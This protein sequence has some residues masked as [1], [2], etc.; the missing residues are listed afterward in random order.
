MLGVRHNVVLLAGAHVP[1][2]DACARYPTAKRE[3][4]ERVGKRTRSDTLV[5][6]AEEQPVSAHEGE[7][8]RVAA[9]H[10]ESAVGAGDCV[11]TRL[12]E[13]M[14]LNVADAARAIGSERTLKR[15]SFR[16]AEYTISA[17]AE[18]HAM[19]PADTR[20]P[21]A[22]M[23]RA[24]VG[25]AGQEDSPS[26]WLS[27]PYVSTQEPLEG[28][29]VYSTVTADVARLTCRPDANERE[30]QIDTQIACSLP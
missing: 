21:S 28:S 7:S 25:L 5:G 19:I 17:R 12:Q 3:R 27:P 6:G 4:R 18:S 9:G 2:P 26:G 8:V 14:T 22:Q 1:A 20:K 24:S 29:H 10:H 23:L 15:Y 16:L 30:Q 11:H 13:M